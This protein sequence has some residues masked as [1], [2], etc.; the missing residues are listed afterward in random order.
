MRRTGPQA[1]I[2]ALIAGG[3]LVLSACGTDADESDEPTEAP[4]E[5]QAASS[6][7]FTYG[8]EQEWSAYNNDTTDSN[9]SKEVVVNN[10]VVQGF[11]RY[12]AD[13]TIE[14]L[15][16][17]GLFEKVSDDPL[18]VEY[19]FNADATWSDGEPIDCDDA[20]LYWYA[21]SGQSETFSPASTTGYEQMESVECADG[22][23]AFTV[24][25]SEPFADWQATFGP[26]VQPAHVLEREAGVDDI[27]AAI[28]SDDTEALDAAAE[29]WNTGWIFNPGELPDEALIPSSGPFKIDS[30]ESGN[31]ITLVANEDYWG[32]PPASETVVI[33]FIAADAQAQALQNGEIQAMDPQPNADLVAQLDAIGDSI[34][35]ETGD[36]FTWEH[37]D[38]QF[39]GVMGDKALREAFALCLPRQ[40]IVDNLIVP[41]NPEAVVQQS[42]YR[43]PFQPEY[44]DAVAATEDLW[45]PYAEQ[46]V[47]A[48][49]AILE[50]ND[51]IGT[52]VRLGYITPNPRREAQA[53]LVID[54]C[55][56][57]GAGF[58][59]IDEGDARF[60]DEE[61]ALVNGNYDV[62]LFAWAGSPL[63]TGSSAIYVTDGGS[64]YQ[65]YSNP[66][67][68]ELTAQ[69]NRT[70]DVAEQSQVIADIERILWEDLVTIPAFT[71]PGIA[72]YDAN[73][74]GVEYNASQGGLTWNME[75]W[76]VQ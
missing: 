14:E 68:D 59:V 31:N 15:P 38:F 27:V 6:G 71:F 61:G 37:Y 34:V 46:D 13:G 44:E 25:Y 24:T 4:E 58:N 53:Q 66:E 7:T 30:W 8:Y 63:V 9:A 3:A 75:D 65:G 17:F 76:S 10:R 57:N 20:Y 42:M 50:E 43:F 60:F 70:T 32:D 23:K 56:E 47:D 22:D 35:V 29:F 26:H 54:A 19:Q 12:A 64:N 33:R 55:G 18:V 1:S 36:Q 62:A 74:T 69:L 40:T 67:I 21:R 72:A 41:Q 16:E 28:D 45:S 48:A 52:D 2:I 73:A 51:A 39:D 49:R 11:W 5:T